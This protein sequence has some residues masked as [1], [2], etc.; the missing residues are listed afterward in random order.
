MKGRTRFALAFAL[1]VAVPFFLLRVNLT[2]YVGKPS[3]W[4]SKLFPAPVT[5]AS[6]PVQK[7][8]P[9]RSSTKEWP[10]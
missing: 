10:A 5:G 9:V 4:P 8:W 3:S 6:R 2:T 1:I 7:L